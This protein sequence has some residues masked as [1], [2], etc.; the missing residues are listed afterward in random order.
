[1]I[2]ME[3]LA[4]FNYVNERGGITVTGIKDR[5][6]CY[7]VDIPEGVTCIDQGAFQGCDYLQILTLPASLKTSIKDAFEGCVR[8][9]EV[10]ITDL[11]AFTKVAFGP[12]KFA[13]PLCYGAELKLNGRRVEDIILA[14]DLCGVGAVAF[15]GCSSLRSV[16]LP[17]S[18]TSIGAYAFSGC[19]AL[20][21][22]SIP[23][24]IKHIGEGAFY[25]CARLKTIYFGG[26]IQAFHKFKKADP[27]FDLLIKSYGVKVNYGRRGDPAE[28]GEEQIQSKDG[29]MH[30]EA[31]KELLTP[32]YYRMSEDGEFTVNRVRRTTMQE[33]RLPEGVVAIDGEAFCDCNKLERIYLPATLRQIGS[34]A[35]PINK[36]RALSEVHIMDLDA[37]CRLKLADFGSNPLFQARRLLLEGEPVEEVVFPEDVDEV[38]CGLFQNLG[39]LRSVTLHDG[40]TKI[41]RAAF[42]GCS[43]LEQISMS[44]GLCELGSDAFYQCA[45]LR[46]IEIP[47]GVKVIPFQCFTGCVGLTE[48]TLP[49]GVT[50]VEQSAFFC[51]SSLSKLTLPSTLTELGKWVVERCD[52]L[53]EIH[54][55]GNKKQWRKVKK[56]KENRALKKKKIICDG[57]K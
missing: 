25:L 4:P 33:S 38:A 52:S 27:S 1:M 46:S 41:G 54:F 42:S 50:S 34:S 22:I 8:L 3:K 12:G 55:A 21:K 20:E 7:V 31:V 47:S 2:D 32:Y 11:N 56:H 18:A 45:S 40:I 16:Y 48:L 13:N 28:F 37:Y 14:P 24:G 6:Y 43:A 49:E 36:C 26:S 30:I 51:C 29:A 35:F 9:R 57:G 15:A 53:T 44:A 17:E 23:A 5:K 10:H 19:T 39:S